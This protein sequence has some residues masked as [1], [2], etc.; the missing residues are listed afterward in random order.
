MRRLARA[1]YAAD[2]MSFSELTLDPPP[3][4]ALP[5]SN[6]APDTRPQTTTRS[7][8]W[9]VLLGGST[10][11][12]LAM[13]MSVLDRSNADGWE[14]AH[15]TVS[16]V[17]ALAA[18]ALS[19]RG[20]QGLTRQIRIGSVAAMTAWLLASLAWLVMV[21]TDSVTVPSIADAFALFFVVPGAWML[22]SSVRGR[23]SRANE[24]A[25][26]LD[27]SLVFLATG[28]VLVALFGPTALAVGGWAGFLVVL[29]PTIFLG[30]AATSLVGIFSTGQSLG[31]RGGLAF[32]VGVG[33]VG[34]GYVGW[35]A[36]TTSG[37]PADH[38]LD[39][40]F[41]VGPLVA[42][43]GAMTWAGHGTDSPFRLRLAGAVT[44]SIGPIAVLIAGIAGAFVDE[45]RSIELFLQ[46]LT[47]VAVF[48][49]LIRTSLH[50][51]ERGEML[52]EV[53]RLHVANQALVERLRHELDDGARIHARLVDASRMSAVGELAAAVAH[54]INNPLTGVLGHT[55]LLLADVPADSRAR[56]DL[57]IIRSEALRVRDRV[58][59]LMD[60]ATPKRSVLVTSDVATVVGRP[61][62]LL[63]YHLGQ[64]GITLDERHEPMPPADLD[65]PSIQQV[66][67][68]IISDMA[69]AMPSGGRLTIS[70]GPA[71]DHARIAVEA[72]APEV[73]LA[74]L[75]AAFQPFDDDPGQIPGS[76]RIAASLGALRGHEATIG[77]HHEPG[78]QP[79]VE[80]H[81]PYRARMDRLAY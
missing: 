14:L 56:S 2:T 42:A 36:P 81:L 6:D 67:I 44:W 51:R 74:L 29:Y 8:M 61:I 65:P 75:A 64:R 63:R 9:M 38:P 17:T 25:V 31:L 37:L 3:T 54:E 13:L 53:K 26:Y 59:S 40:L 62:G 47:A 34:L 50:L 76:R 60:F 18:T 58:R 15:W 19:V 5:A 77:L 12:G 28:A 39:L 55:E 71:V 27:N 10:L 4:A 20:S 69:A 16:A 11:T 45:S 78:R 79:L 46:A 32:G 22:V 68:N 48:L 30:A 49:L 66:V 70:T 73:D 57:E 80:I 24:K 43:Y 1:P 21:A 33:L 7:A 41:S 72:D 52:A 23:L 35:I